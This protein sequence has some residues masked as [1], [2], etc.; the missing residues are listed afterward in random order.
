M[1]PNKLAILQKLEEERLLVKRLEKYHIT[2]LGAVL[3]A[4]DLH[5][6]EQRARKVPRVIIYKGNNKLHTEREQKGKYGFAVAF[7]RLVNY[8]NDKL[9]SNEEIDR[10][11]R[12]EVRV[13]P[14]L[15]IREL[16]ANALIHQDFSIKGT[17]VMIEIFDN[18]IE[19]TNPGKPLI[20]VKRFIDHSPESR[21]EMLAG[22]MRRLNICEER[23]SGVDKVIAQV[24]M[25]QLPAPE[26]IAGENYTRG[27]Q[28]IVD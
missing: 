28:L 14:E 15:A 22:M 10:V 4:R 3:F 7:E 19:V 1:P 18:R 2:N 26:F 27:N 5:D 6:F 23:G 8:V 24:E 12:K 17:S 16:V 25:F 13:Y 21:N 9:P 20:D 11:F